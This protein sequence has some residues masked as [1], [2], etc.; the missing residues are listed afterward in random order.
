MKKSENRE[1]SKKSRSENGKVKTSFR[2]TENNTQAVGIGLPEFEK[3]RML[4]VISASPLRLLYRP[5]RAGIVLE[6]GSW[7]PAKY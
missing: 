5:M 1:N 6:L 7:Q 2:F 3:S 4:A